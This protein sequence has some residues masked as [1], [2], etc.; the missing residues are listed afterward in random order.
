MAHSLFQPVVSSMQCMVKKDALQKKPS[1]PSE[2]ASRA[3]DVGMIFATSS[4]SVNNVTSWSFVFPLEG[5]Q[6]SKYKDHVKTEAVNEL[7]GHVINQ[8]ML[9]VITM[10]SCSSKSARAGYV[11]TLE[12]R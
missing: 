1:T 8:S 4:S 2:R 7:F 10:L 12:S 5:F 9:E 3:G 6:S 11:M